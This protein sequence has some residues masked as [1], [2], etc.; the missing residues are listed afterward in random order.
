MPFPR[1]WVEELIIEWLQLEGFL[2]QSNLP[3]A[4]ARAG[5]RLEADVVG[6]E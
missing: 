1:T 2:A 3:V 5:G 6:Q 4:V